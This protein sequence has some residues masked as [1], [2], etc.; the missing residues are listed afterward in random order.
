MPS[1]ERG[2]QREITETYRGGNI[3]IEQR[4]EA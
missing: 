4:D 2:G 1:Q 3:R